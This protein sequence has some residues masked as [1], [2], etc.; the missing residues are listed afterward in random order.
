MILQEV[1]LISVPGVVGQGLCNLVIRSPELHTD[2]CRSVSGFP[3]IVSQH[4]DKRELAVFWT[5]AEKTV[6]SVIM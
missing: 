6:W 2:D 3:S 4:G 1:L 5:L